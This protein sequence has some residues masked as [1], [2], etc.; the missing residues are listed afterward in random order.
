MSIHFLESHDSNVPRTSSE[1]Y[2]SLLPYTQETVVYSDQDIPRSYNY[3]PLHDDNEVV[4]THD[5][6]IK[7]SMES[8]IGKRIQIEQ[9]SKANRETI[10]VHR[11]EAK[12]LYDEEGDEFVSN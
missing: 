10:S 1:L 2:R 5:E 8:A 12:S 7:T 6:T 9:R 4:T 3:S 11:Q